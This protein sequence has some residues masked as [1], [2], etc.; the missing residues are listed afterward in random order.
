MLGAT[1]IDSSIVA[2]IVNLCKTCIGL[3]SEFPLNIFMIG[4]LIGIGFG[5][6]RKAKKSL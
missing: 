5:I 1:V 2:E 4:G 6:F 3:F